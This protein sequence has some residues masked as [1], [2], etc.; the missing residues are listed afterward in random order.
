MTKYRVTCAKTKEGEENK[1]AKEVLGEIVEVEHLKLSE[2]LIARLVG[3]EDT[4]LRTS[5]VEAYN[6][7]WKTSSI[8][9][10]QTKNSVYTFRKVKE[11][12]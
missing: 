7:D 1:V 4:C 3:R 6:S 11:D 12:E 2:S 5:P 9:T 10:V 8:L